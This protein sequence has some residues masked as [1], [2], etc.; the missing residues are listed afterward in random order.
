[1]VK[2]LK[3]LGPVLVLIAI[4]VVITVIVMLVLSFGV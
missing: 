1:M 2:T 3:S 4:G